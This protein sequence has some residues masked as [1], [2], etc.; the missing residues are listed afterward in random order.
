M[1]DLRAEI[2]RIDDEMLTLFLKR[3]KIVEKIALEKKKQGLDVLNQ[4]R[5]KEVLTRLLSKIENKEI[6]GLYPKFIT[7]VMDISK[8]YQSYLIKE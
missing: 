7:N 3:M 5:E 2:D 6:A 4:D 8:L 1:N